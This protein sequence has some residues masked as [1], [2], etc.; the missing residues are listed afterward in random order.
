V[1]AL[2]AVSTSN[3]LTGPGAV[4][5]VTSFTDASRLEPGGKSRPFPLVFKLHDVWPFVQGHTTK[6][7]FRLVTAFSRVLGHIAK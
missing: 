1:A 4:W 6:F 5:D 2:E 7:D 3:G